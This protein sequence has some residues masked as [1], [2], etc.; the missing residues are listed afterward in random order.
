MMKMNFNGLAFQVIGR[1]SY[2]NGDCDLLNNSQCG[3][4]SLR[5]AQKHMAFPE[6]LQKLKG[7]GKLWHRICRKKQRNQLKIIQI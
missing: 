1:A 7:K 2:S 4:L 3:T 6:K 5:M